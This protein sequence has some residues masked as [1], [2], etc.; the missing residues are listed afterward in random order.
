MVKIA[1]VRT[2]VQCSLAREAKKTT[3]IAPGSVPGSDIV[4]AVG[5]ARYKRGYAT[6]LEPRMI[7]V[8]FG[9]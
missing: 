1:R 4:H 6:G 3:S 7:A 9:L 5:E 8:V 2:S